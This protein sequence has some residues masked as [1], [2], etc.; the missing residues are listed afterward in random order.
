YRFNGAYEDSDSFRDFG[1]TERYLVAP[2]VRWFLNDDT[3]LTWEGEL[4]EDKRRG[5]VGIAAIGGDVLALPRR[6][7]LGEPASDFFHTKDQR[8][9]VVLDHRFDD[10]WGIQIGAST[11]FYDI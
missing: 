10:D 3:M 8:T 9:S 2:S 5:D 11:V 7:Y 6:R 1:F 4:L